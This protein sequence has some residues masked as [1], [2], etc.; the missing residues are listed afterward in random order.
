MKNWINFNLLIFS[1]QLMKLFSFFIINN[2]F[3]LNMFKRNQ[4]RKANARGRK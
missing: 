2:N 3:Y 4:V 1:I